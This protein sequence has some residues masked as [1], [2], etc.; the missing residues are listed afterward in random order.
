MADSGSFLQSYY[1]YAK[2][3]VF[4]QVAYGVL[5]AST[6]FRSFY[7]MSYR[8]RPDLEKRNPKEA[9][10]IMSEMW[11]LAW[12]GLSAPEFPRLSLQVF[13]H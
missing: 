5:T 6:I 10:R 13:V 4:H 7:D 12:I 3:P 9:D 11:K 8:L 1:L 2:D